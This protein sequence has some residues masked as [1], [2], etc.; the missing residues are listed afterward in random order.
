M[1]DDYDPPRREV[2][3][4][5]GMCGGSGD[6]HVQNCPETPDD[7]PE[8]ETMNVTFS[9]LGLTFEAKCEYEPYIPAQIS[10][11]PE[12]CYPAEG[13]TAAI[14]DLSCNGA[15]AL[16]L[17]ESKLADEL[18]DAAY[19]ACVD[20]DEAQREAA[21]EARAEERRLDRSYA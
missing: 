8:P 13:G 2:R 4:I 21:A 20:A 19:Q 18:T 16:F 6:R 10:G 14:R 3:A 1:F 9:L 15:D 11:P 5:C 7:P 12:R 17:L